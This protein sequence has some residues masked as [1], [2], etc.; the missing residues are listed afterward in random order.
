MQMG[1]RLT[2][3]VER[4][5]VGGRMIARYNG[6]VVFVAGAIPG[7]V[8]EAIVERVQRG[9]VWAST[10]RVVEGS[11][12]RLPGDADRACGGCAF[13]HIAYERQRQL[14]AAII[15]D[16]FRRIGRLTLDGPVPVVPS[17]VDGYRMRARLHA[18]GGRIGFFREGTHEL[19]DPAPTRQLQPAALDAVAALSKALQALERETVAAIELSE[20]IDGRDRVCHLELVPDAD[21]SRLASLTAVGHLTGVTCAHAGRP[22]TMEL[23]GEPRVSDTIAVTSGARTHTVTLARHARAFFQSNRY[24]LVPLVNHV[25]SVVE[26]GPL[27]DLFAGVGLF[28]VAAAAC[29]VGPVVAVEGDRF[30]I[31]D[32]QGN[33]TP[34]AETLS[35]RGESVEAFVARPRDVKAATVILD[36]PRT[37]LS[38]EAL[39]GVLALAAPRLIYVSCDIAT[40]ARDAQALVGA[41]YAIV[42]AR[43]F[44][45]FP[46]TAHVEAVISFAR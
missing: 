40:L 22:R 19:C 23:W 24:L 30:A 4:P 42:G 14:K 20:N 41:G 27:V 29:G 46:N 2:L 17:P 5:A 6:A 11:P 44:D 38:K 7:E 39:A 37:G 28:S 33:A 15:D 10:A 9:T 12:D 25:L 26:K 34:Y 16:A 43:A 45:L 31:D 8:V 36:P 21:P 13:A 32:L 18:S 1:D 35:V 3:S